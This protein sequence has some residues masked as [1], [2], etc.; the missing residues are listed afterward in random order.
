LIKGAATRYRPGQPDWSK[1]RIYTTTLAI[2]AGVAGPATQPTAL[3]LGR[4]DQSGRLRYV[5]RSHRLSTAAQR[6]VVAASLRPATGHPWPQP[7]PAAWAGSFN[8]GHPVVY[9]QVEPETVAEVE[10]DPAVEFG[11][12]RHSARFV[13]IRAELR[14]KQL[15][16]IPDHDWVEPGS[17]PPRAE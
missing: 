10:V 3:L 16:R 13:R 12:W 17:P 4:F 1:Y 8:R 7:L 15:P 11:R 14:P 6:V 2:I 5:A 9:T